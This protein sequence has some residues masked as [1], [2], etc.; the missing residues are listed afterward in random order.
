[1]PRVGAIILAAGMSTRMGT[2]KF[3]L[4]IQSQPM[5]HYPIKL[6]LQQN[7][8]PIIIIAGKYLNEI[9][10]ATRVFPTITYIHNESYQTGMASSLKKG[11]EGMQG[12]A[13]AAMIF[14]ADQPFIPGSVVKSMLEAYMDGGLIIRPSFAG[15]DSHPVLFDASLFPLFAKLQGDEGGRRIINHQPPSSVK[16]LF[17]QDQEAGLDIDTPEVYQKYHER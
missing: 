1:M 14:L 7:L 11:I 13:D 15:Q 16:R 9:K 17:F 8:S 2:P 3:L 4:P 12:K 6:A 10:E 5:I